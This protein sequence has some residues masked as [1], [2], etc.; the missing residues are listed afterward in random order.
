MSEESDIET[1]EEQLI[2]LAFSKEEAAKLARAKR[3]VGRQV[4]GKKSEQRY[5]TV[6]EIQRMIDHKDCDHALAVDLLT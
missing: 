5:W 1:R 2:E 4:R 3:Y 6:T